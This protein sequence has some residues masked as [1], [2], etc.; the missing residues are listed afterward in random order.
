MTRQSTPDR[1]SAYERTLAQVRSNKPD[2][3]DW[4]LVE[5]R[6]LARI[7]GE[8]VDQPPRLVV[9]HQ[10]LVRESA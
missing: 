6:L 8:T 7:D 2:E 1:D 5:S 3:L 9:P 10:L 4:E